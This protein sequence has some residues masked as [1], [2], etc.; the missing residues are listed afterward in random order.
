MPHFFPFNSPAFFVL[1]ML[2]EY[3]KTSLSLQLHTHASRH[4]EDDRFLC[5]LWY[6]NFL[7]LAVANFL[8]FAR[9]E[10]NYIAHSSTLYSASEW[11]IKNLRSFRCVWDILTDYVDIIENNFKWPRRPQRSPVTTKS[12]AKSFA[13]LLAEMV[14]IVNLYLV[15]IHKL[16]TRLELGFLRRSNWMCLE[17]FK[18]NLVNVGSWTEAS[19]QQHLNMRYFRKFTFILRWG[20]FRNTECLD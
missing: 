9:I 11:K 13:R 2:A 6:P 4:F 7:S 3:K 8:S 16:I 20:W 14:Y 15:Y 12:L 19:Q 10:S 18:V 5:L 17:A 1:A